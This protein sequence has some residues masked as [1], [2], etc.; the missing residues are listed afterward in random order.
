MCCTITH[1][2][3]II[4]KDYKP[5]KSLVKVTPVYNQFSYIFF[6]LKLYIIIFIMIKYIK[7]RILS[8]FT[9]NE[10]RLLRLEEV[11]QYTI[12]YTIITIVISPLIDQIFPE[13]DKTKSKATIMVEIVIQLIFISIVIFYIKKIV[14]I[15]PPLGLLVNSNYKTGTTSEY[16]GGIVMGLI[17][18]HSQEKL[19]QKILYLI[20]KVG[21]H[22]R[23][24]QSTLTE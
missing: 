3:N 22:Y 20:D 5:Q 6:F 16:N 23:D 12:L 13:L 19:P 7:D 24:I 10:I 21:E 18:V 17:L 8:L 14:K 1:S 11:I 2:F 15:I 4:D 9:L